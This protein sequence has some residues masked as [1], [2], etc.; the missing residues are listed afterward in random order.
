MNIKH[1]LFDSTVFVQGFNETIF[2][3]VLFINSV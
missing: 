3:V 1:I 2:N